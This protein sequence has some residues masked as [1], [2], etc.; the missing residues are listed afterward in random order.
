MNKS[1]LQSSPGVTLLLDPDNWPQ[2]D[3]ETLL[4]HPELSRAVHA[5]VVGGSY[6]HSDR[7]AD[8][9][10]LA[11]GRGLPLGTFLGAGPIDSLLSP[12]ADFVLLPV[13][14]GATSSRFVL[15]HVL[16]AAPVI[17]RFRLDVCRIGYIQLQG[18]PATSASFFTQITPVPRGKPE[19]VETLALAAA[20]L[21]VHAIYLEA[22]SAAGEPVTQEE[23]RAA[24]RGSALPVFVGGGI[25]SL[26]VCRNLLSEGAHSVFVGSHVERTRSI[27]WLLSV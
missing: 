6:V 1:I 20:Y 8:T 15:D 25:R 23:L 13:A 7:F 5:I 26:A 9:I 27:E 12:Y 4:A 16:M 2:S 11:A 24:I 22:G 19:L 3:L 21:G 10:T 18:G 17:R 14:I